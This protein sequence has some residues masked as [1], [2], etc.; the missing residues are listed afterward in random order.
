MCISHKLTKNAPFL[1][2]M[3]LQDILSLPYGLKKSLPI[4]SVYITNISINLIILSKINRLENPYASTYISLDL[5][6]S[7]CVYQYC[8]GSD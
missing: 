7:E 5:T 6:K 2:W 8:L 4:S 1:Y 3:V